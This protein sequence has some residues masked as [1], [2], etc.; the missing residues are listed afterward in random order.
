MKTAKIWIMVC[1]LSTESAFV[2]EEKQCCKHSDTLEVFRG[3][4]RE[5]QAHRPGVCNGQ[6]GWNYIKNAFSRHLIQW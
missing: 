6:I 1:N 3:K 4:F 2:L 5:L